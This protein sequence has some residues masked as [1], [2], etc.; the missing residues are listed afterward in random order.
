MSYFNFDIDPNAD[1]NCGVKIARSTRDLL[2][3][4]AA[5]PRRQAVLPDTLTLAV[6]LDRRMPAQN[7]TSHAIRRRD[8][9]QAI[10]LHC[11]AQGENANYRNFR[12]STARSS[13]SAW[14]AYFERLDG[15]PILWEGTGRSIVR[16]TSY[17]LETLAIADAQISIDDYLASEPSAQP[18]DA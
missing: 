2:K 6:D 18:V 15:R 3:T 9:Q 8:A 11:S 12:I 7:R 16:T 14:V 4:N 10:V 17:S 13:D 1:F 5:K